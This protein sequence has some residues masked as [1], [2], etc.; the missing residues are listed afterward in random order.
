MILPIITDA[1]EEVDWKLY[2]ITTINSLGLRLVN[3]KHP[4][5]FAH[6]SVIATQ[7]GLVGNREIPCLQS[8]LLRI[9]LRTKLVFELLFVFL[10]LRRVRLLAHT[11]LS[12]LVIDGEL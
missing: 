12:G 7:E 2:L 4:C 11:A 9:R 3:F 1:S 10:F 6:L 8:F 5:P